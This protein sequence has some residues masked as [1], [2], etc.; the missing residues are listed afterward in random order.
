MP[1]KEP[2]VRVPSLTLAVLAAF[3]L[4]VFASWLEC[5]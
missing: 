2:E 3:S 1:N 4:L 5:L